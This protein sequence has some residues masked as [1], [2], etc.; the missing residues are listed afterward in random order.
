MNKKL[1]KKITYQGRVYELPEYLELQLKIRHFQEPD[2]LLMPLCSRIKNGR[3]WIDDGWDE[4]RGRFTLSKAPKFLGIYKEHAEYL[5]NIKIKPN[6][7][8]IK[9]FLNNVYTG[10]TAEIKTLSSLEKEVD[11]LY[12]KDKAKAEQKKLELYQLSLKVRLA[13]RRHSLGKGSVEVVTVSE[14]FCYLGKRH[15]DCDKE[16]F[17]YEIKQQLFKVIDETSD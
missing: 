10:A 5:L 8:I 7:P 4:P 15:F 16:H 6:S 2:D 12:W 9:H 3:L 13:A 14:M 1:S 17:W 11:E